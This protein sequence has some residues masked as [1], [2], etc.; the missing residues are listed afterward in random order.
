MKLDKNQQV[1]LALLRAGLWEKEVRCP[2]LCEVDHKA[3]FALAQEQSVVGLVAAG[4]EH[5]VD[6]SVPREV[7]MKYM[8]AVLQLEKRNHAMNAFIGTLFKNLDIAGIHPLLV[9]GQ[10]VAQCYDRPMW[11]AAG[12]V[13]LLIDYPHYGEAREF[14]LKNADSA[15]VEIDEMVHQAA[16]FGPWDVELHGSLHGIWSPKVDM[17][18]D[19]LQ[20][21]CFEN[22]Q[23]RE[24]DNN[25]TIINLPGME[26]DII[27]VFTHILQHFF[28]G[29]IGLRQIC[30]LS[31]L[32]W[33]YHKEIDKPVLEERL[34]CM[35]I[36]SEWKV[37]AALCVLYLGLPEESMPL[38]SRSGIWGKK[39][40]RL[41]ILLLERRLKGFAPDSESRSI[42]ERKLISLKQ[43]TGDMIRQFLIFPLDSVKVWLRTVRNGVA[44]LLSSDL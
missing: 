13:D 26:Y 3:V 14:L 40:K 19:A 25:G 5:L 23:F 4:L 22:K 17:A 32:L 38:Y 44:G 15:D 35:G 10:G 9:K 28:R 1:F 18:L 43:H 27:F 37:F 8:V 41:L 16:L 39:A 12:D 30:D 20:K 21:E 42:N 2:Q 34:R 7:S 6:A 36:M 11:R 29:G 31:R 24:W 33:R